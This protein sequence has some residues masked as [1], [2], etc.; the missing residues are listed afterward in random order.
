MTETAETVEQQN[1]DAESQQ[2]QNT[3]AQAVEFAQANESVAKGPGNSIDILLDMQAEITVTIG[4]IQMPIK[5]LLQLTPGSVVKLEKNIQ[6][7]VDLY[8]NDSRFATGS[9]IVIEDSFGI[10]INDILD[11][12][13]SDSQQ[14]QDQ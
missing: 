11:V 10:K 1:S 7:P 13:N 5:K 12:T 2:S 4:K 8:I 9:I 6:E 14:I 3:S